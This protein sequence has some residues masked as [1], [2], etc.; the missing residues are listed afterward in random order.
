[1]PQQL[2]TSLSPTL[3]Q[4]YIICVLFFLYLIHQCEFTCAEQKFFA[5]SL[6]LFFCDQ[7]CC[8]LALSAFFGLLSPWTCVF[9]D[10]QEPDE[11]ANMSIPDVTCVYG[12]LTRNEWATDASISVAFSVTFFLWALYWSVVIRCSSATMDAVKL[13]HMENVDKMKLNR[14]F[15]WRLWWCQADLLL[16]YMVA[17][18]V[19]LFGHEV[20]TFFTGRDNVI[21]G[22]L[23]TGA[24]AFAAASQL[25]MSCMW[26]CCTMDSI[27]V[28][29][30]Y[31]ALW[32]GLSCVLAMVVIA[33]DYNMAVQPFSTLGLS[34]VY[35]VAGLLVGVPL[36]LC[37]CR[38]AHRSRIA[39]EA[40]LTVTFYHSRPNGGKNADLPGR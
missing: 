14:G 7:C 34:G 22:L 11:T 16:K 39:S 9:S 26:K 20:S 40:Y 3:L 36:C 33:L 31:L 21:K 1:M 28:L 17:C 12:N 38:R 8:T 2:L 5:G 37:H 19:S 13:P 25:L 29:H 6:Y 18:V 10:A 23:C 27:N 30:Q 35:C 24:G 15:Q 32:A 4:V